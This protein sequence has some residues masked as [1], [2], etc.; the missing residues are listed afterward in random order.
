MA[1]AID[2]PKDNYGE[3][4]EEGFEFLELIRE[5]SL[6]RKGRLSHGRSGDRITC[7]TLDLFME[8]RQILSGHTEES[9]FNFCHRG[10]NPLSTFGIGSRAQ[11]R[12]SNYKSRAG[13]GILLIGSSI[14]THGASDRP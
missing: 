12:I 7:H 4:I 9:N 10:V 1:G 6:L 8:T 14:C 13:S 2:R 3:V 5:D 11:F